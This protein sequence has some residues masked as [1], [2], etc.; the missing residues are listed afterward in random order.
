MDDNLNIKSEVSLVDCS[1]LK[2]TVRRNFQREIYEK[3][4][5]LNVRGNYNG[6]LASLTRNDYTFLIQ[7]LQSFGEKT[8]NIDPDLNFNE[9]AVSREISKKNKSNQMATNA[10]VKA[11]KSASNISVQFDVKSIKMHLHN[12][13]TVWV[14]YAYS[15]CINL[16]TRKHN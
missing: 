15:I 6:L 14:S 9:T 1:D 16:L 10:F 12:Q 13:D 11:K 2:L 5:M 4:E 8:I 3:I 7:V